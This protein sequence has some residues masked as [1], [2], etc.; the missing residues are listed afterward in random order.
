MLKYIL[1][2]RTT[3]I[4]N[5]RSIFDAKYQADDILERFNQLRIWIRLNLRCKNSN[6]VMC[7]SYVE[8]AMLILKETCES[9]VFESI[10]TE[11]F[12]DYCHYFWDKPCNAEVYTTLF[13]LFNRFVPSSVGIYGYQQWFDILPKPLTQSPSKKASNSNSS[14]RAAWVRHEQE[15]IH[16]KSVSSIPLIPGAILM[17][18]Q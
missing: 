7:H 16:C 2:L 13:A 11:L 17:Q 6:V 12:L 1:L 18:S 8:I 4:F 9:S 14:R 3:T 10:F 5:K 15:V